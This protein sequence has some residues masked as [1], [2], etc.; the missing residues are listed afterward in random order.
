LALLEFGNKHTFGLDIGSYSVKVVQLRKEKSGYIATSAAQS[1]IG[2][3][4]D[5][6]QRKEA[7]E[8]LE[9]IKSGMSISQIQTKYAVCSVCGPEVFMKGFK[10]PP[11]SSEEIEQAVLL[12]AE[13]SV[14][15]DI[16]QSIVDYNL[17]P[18]SNRS[19]AIRSEGG[20]GS[21]LQGIIVAASKTLI[22][23]RKQLAKKSSLSCALVDI[24]GLA[25]LNCFLETEPLAGDQ[26][27][28]ILNVGRS[29]TNLIFVRKGVP[30][31]L[32]DLPHAGGGIIRELVRDLDEPSETIDELLFTQETSNHEDNS[33]AAN[34]SKASQKLISDITETMRY[35][36]IQHKIKSVDRVLL[37][38][39]FS[40]AR[41]F[42]RVLDSHLTAEVELWDPFTRIRWGK[43]TIGQELLKHSGPAFAVAAGLAMRTL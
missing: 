14:P 7:G 10:F 34:L 8:V 38:G 11:L 12:E 16:E 37:C 29:Y 9:A 35:Y 22:R 41:G 19:E 24:D 4:R 25:L 20:R 26:T 30:P 5:K 18:G 28:V 27:V 17:L 33:I 13:Q 23:E 40:L 2:P 15:F 6:G 39:G 32:R 43:A 42:D 1:V 3:N 31:F 21:D 36:N